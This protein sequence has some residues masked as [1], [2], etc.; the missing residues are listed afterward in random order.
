MSDEEWKSDAGSD[1]EDSTAHAKLMA[2]IDSIAIKP[3]TNKAAGGLRHNSMAAGGV[4]LGALASLDQQVSSAAALKEANPI[5]K[6]KHKRVLRKEGYAVLAEDLNKWAGVVHHMRTAKQ[7]TFPL[8]DNKV[9]MFEQDHR[10]KPQLK[11]SLQKKL[12]G[13]MNDAGLIKAKEETPQE[14]EIREAL[15]LEEVK[16]R[17]TDAWRLRILR[18]KIGKK[19]HLRN[20]TKSKKYHR[21]LKKDRLKKQAAELENLK[22]VDPNKALE[23]LQELEEIRIE[24]RMSLKHKKSKWATQLQRRANTDKDALAKLQE[25]ARLHTELMQKLQQQQEDLQDEDASSSGDSDDDEDQAETVTKNATPAPGVA[26]QAYIK[27]KKFWGEYNR[28]KEEE[29]KDRIEEIRKKKNVPQK[30]EEELIIEEAN[31][32]IKKE[33]SARKKKNKNCEADTDDKTPTITQFELTFDSEKP[34]QPL[35][36]GAVRLRTIED[37]ENLGPDKTS[38]TEAAAATPITDVPSNKQLKGLPEVD[39]THFKALETK[40]LS[41]AKSRV[42]NLFNDDGDSDADGDVNNEL[43]DEDDNALEEFN[44]QKQAAEEAAQVKDECYALPGWGEWASPDCLISQ[45]KIEKYTIKA[46]K[47][48]PAKTGNFIYNEKADLHPAIRERMVKEL[49]YPF[50][51]VSDWEASVRFP[52]S[53]AFVPETVHQKI[54]APRV[55]RKAGQVIKPLDQSHLYNQPEIKRAVKRKMQEAAKSDGKPLQ[56]EPACKKMVAFKKNPKKFNRT[57]VV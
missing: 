23:K 46:P 2:D 15:S 43:F 24:E 13:L 54:I 6:Q 21:E 40:V 4:D 8:P 39:A 1:V 31:K 50:K 18:D 19:A 27:M 5:A 49:P 34:D 25:N 20:K 9:S 7:L 17:N 55:V 22:K 44:K 33:M 30:G 11:T 28:Q 57:S 35:H 42:S 3:K 10:T 38:A 48:P 29:L 14:K 47:K 41:S 51:S 45:K 37:Y 26:D 12:F 36:E 16:A 32:I 53:R 56:S 52:I